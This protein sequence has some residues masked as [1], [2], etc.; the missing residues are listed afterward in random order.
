[1]TGVKTGKFNVF[2]LFDKGAIVPVIRPLLITSIW[3]R[4]TYKLTFRFYFVWGYLSI[5]T[6]SR[7]HFLP[8]YC[9]GRTSYLKVVITYFYCRL[10]FERVSYISADVGRIKKT[11]E[12]IFST[13][14]VSRIARIFGAQL[15][16]EICAFIVVTASIH[17]ARFGWKQQLLYEFWIMYVVH[18]GPIVGRIPRNTRVPS[19]V[20]IFPA[21]RWKLRRSL[22]FL[23]D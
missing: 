19:S 10:I 14:K 23:P 1:M 3:N 13:Y 16:P 7:R 17:K 9:F 12:N 4:R 11:H 20:L 21:R 5:T 8:I 22:R 18:H 15:T 6:I 2:S